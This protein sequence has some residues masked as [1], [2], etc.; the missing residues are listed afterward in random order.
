MIYKVECDKGCGYTQETE[1]IEDK[2]WL[3]PYQCGACGSKDIRVW[4]LVYD[5]LTIKIK[6]RMAA[7]G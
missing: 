1:P 6:E 5:A 4:A 2:S 7:N 3:R